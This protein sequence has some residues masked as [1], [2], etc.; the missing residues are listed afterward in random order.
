[1]VL[2]WIF[3]LARLVHAYIHTGY[4]DVWQRGTAMGVA[5]LTLLIMWVIFAVRILITGA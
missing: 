5:S 1:V 4:N 3:V 2:A